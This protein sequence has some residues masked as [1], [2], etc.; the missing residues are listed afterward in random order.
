MSEMDDDEVLPAD[1]V[2]MQNFLREI[3]IDGGDPASFFE[4][5]CNAC[6]RVMIRED[7]LERCPAAELEAGNLYVGRLVLALLC[8]IAYS[9]YLCGADRQ[10]HEAAFV[11]VG[12]SIGEVGSR[13]AGALATP[14]GAVATRRAEIERLLSAID[15]QNGSVLP[16]LLYPDPLVRE[17]ECYRG[18]SFSECPNEAYEAYLLVA[19]VPGVAA[20]PAVRSLLAARFGG[21]RPRYHY[22]P[23]DYPPSE[24]GEELTRWI[25]E[26]TW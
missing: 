23:F 17:C 1:V 4:R 11:F 26:G 21:E 14:P 7:I 2:A 22:Q 9:E 3:L 16:A 12:T 24:M 19:A 5:E 6:V 15:E 20:A 8:K 10:A 25:R 18:F 13:I